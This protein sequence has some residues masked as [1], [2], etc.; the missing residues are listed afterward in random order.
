MKQTQAQALADARA[1][2]DEDERCQLNLFT[3]QGEAPPALPPAIPARCPAVRIAGWCVRRNC[4]HW[5]DRCAHPAAWPR[6]RSR[7]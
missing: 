6:R 3:P 1:R 4:R 7:R 5:Q 2:R